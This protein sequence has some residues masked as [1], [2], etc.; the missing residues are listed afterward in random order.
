L[1]AI[2]GAGAILGGVFPPD[3]RDHWNEPPSTSGTI[4]S[5]AAMIAFLAFPPA[6]LLLS[7]TRTQRI[8]AICSALTLLVFF[9]CLSPVFRHQAPLA[10]GLV[11]RVLLGFYLAWLAT[12]SAP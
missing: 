9:V 8:L 7:R 1:L 2:W 6:A 3:P 10:L 5:G 12:R 4:H 11:E